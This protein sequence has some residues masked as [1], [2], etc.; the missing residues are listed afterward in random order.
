MQEFLL[1]C[2]VA[3]LTVIVFALGSIERRIKEKR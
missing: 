2:V 3:Q 1:L